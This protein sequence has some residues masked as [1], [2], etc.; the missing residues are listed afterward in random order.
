MA[1]GWSIATPPSSDSHVTPSGAL[2]FS[3]VVHYLQAEW[4]RFDLERN[5]WAFERKEFVAHIHHLEQQ[6]QSAKRTIDDLHL[7][8]K[9]LQQN[10]KKRRFKPITKFKQLRSLGSS[11]ELHPDASDSA[12]SASLSTRS[13]DSAKDLAPA[14]LRNPSDHALSL[15][16][17]RRLLERACAALVQ[18][19]LT[20]A[21]FP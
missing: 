7:E 4:R 13:T 21:E 14:S 9:R 1:P 6:H 3:R 2:T 20:P 5:E 8:I 12:S 11:A 10:T 17:L 18:A 15:A 16:E 19:K